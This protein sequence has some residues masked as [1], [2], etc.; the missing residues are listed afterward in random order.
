[1]ADCGECWEKTSLYKECGSISLLQERQRKNLRDA[2]NEKQEGIQGQRQQE[3]PAKEF[4]EQVKSSADTDCTPK[5]RCGY[6][7]EYKIFFSLEVSATEWAFER[8]RGKR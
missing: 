2:E 3:S 1:M 4:L 7:E 8:I 6:W 5:M